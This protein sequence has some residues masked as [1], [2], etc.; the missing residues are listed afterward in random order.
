VTL[1]S[2]HRLQEAFRQ[3]RARF[4]ILL[5]RAENDK[6]KRFPDGLGL[7]FENS[8]RQYGRHD[9]WRPDHVTHPRQQWPPFVSKPTEKQLASL[10]HVKELLNNACWWERD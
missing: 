1:E 10:V 4:A 6:G 2:L 8:W 5:K 3:A 9:R 7:F